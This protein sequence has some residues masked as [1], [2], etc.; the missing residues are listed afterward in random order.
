MSSGGKREGPVGAGPGCGFR[1]WRG[2][3]G[4]WLGP[5]QHGAAQRRGEAHEDPS[6]CPRRETRCRR[7]LCPV[8]ATAS[9]AQ[10]RLPRVPRAAVTG[11]R[12]RGPPPVP[13]RPPGHP[14]ITEPPSTLPPVLTQERVPTPHPEASRGRGWKGPPPQPKLGGSQAPPENRGPGSGSAPGLTA[15][16]PPWAQRPPLLF[17]WGKEKLKK[18][19]QPVGVEGRAEAGW[20]LCGVLQHAGHQFFLRALSPEWALR[21]SPE[22]PR[23][24][25]QARFL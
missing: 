1:A 24:E 9:P 15:A 12:Q 18:S 3:A 11:T 20:P 19:G 6:T 8:G 17:C 14:R 2:V 21:L 5:S 7:Y 4:G 23:V 10:H 16:S 13:G 25:P 22:R